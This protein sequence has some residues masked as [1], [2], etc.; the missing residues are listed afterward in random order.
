MS[1]RIQTVN[2][3]AF[4]QTCFFRLTISR[5]GARAKVRSKEAL[6]VYLDQLDA[7]A[8]AGQAT[9]AAVDI[10]GGRVINGGGALKATVG[11]Y[12]PPPRNAD[13]TDAENP[14]ENIC[15]FLSSTKDRLVGRFGK[16][17]PSRIAEGLFV[18]SNNLVQEYEDELRAAVARLR[19]Q[20]IPPLLADYPAAIDR[21][22]LPV[23]QGGLGPLYD[24]RDFPTVGKL[25]SLFGLEW[26]WLALGVPENLPAALRAEAAEK[27][28]RQ[29]T[30]AANEVRDALRTAFA[31]LVAHAQ[32]RLTDGQDGKRKIFRDSLI[33]NIQNFIGVFSHRNVM[34][35]TDLAQLV[36]RARQVMVGVTP[37]RIRDYAS[38]RDNMR[39]QFEQI[40]TALDGMIT[41]ETG[42]KFDLSE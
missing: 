8:Q 26:Q 27:M 37:E 30:E 9:R 6:K 41:T 32:E 29:M 3:E 22:Q 18:V 39:S 38:V 7:A 12:V 5:W 15:A 11:L 20:F 23:A 1:A 24:A 4:Q 31:E 16:A 28:E 33:E 2:A 14:Y 19:D 34:N 35:D 21:A 25:A 40:R 13:G 17:S 10:P 36:D 42:R